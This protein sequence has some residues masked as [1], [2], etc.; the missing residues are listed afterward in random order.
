MLCWQTI[1]AAGWTKLLNKE[2][3]AVVYG[4]LAAD[5]RRYVEVYPVNDGA[6][7]ALKNTAAGNGQRQSLLNR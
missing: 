2:L 6:G 4:D 5:K 1:P 3:F 7:F